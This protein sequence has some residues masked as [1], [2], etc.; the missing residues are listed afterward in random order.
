ME[1]EWDAV[2]DWTNKIFTFHQKTITKDTLETLKQLLFSHYKQQYYT[3]KTTEHRSI[4][5]SFPQGE[6]LIKQEQGQLLV[7]IDAETK[8]KVYALKQAI[9]ERKLH[10]SAQTNDDPFEEFVSFSEKTF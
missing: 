10:K 6:V 5:I 2:R 3:F 1:K 9:Q 7:S 4:V 8:Q